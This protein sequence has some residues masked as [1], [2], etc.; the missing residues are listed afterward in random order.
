VTRSIL[1]L[2]PAH[3]EADQV[4]AVLRGIHV[5]QPDA[6]ILVV[7]DGSSDHTANVA[8]SCGARVIRHAFNLGYGAALQTGYL[9]A[10]RHGYSRVVQM[11]ADG[12]H[13]PSSIA[14]LLA[15]LDDGADVVVG[16]RYRV[17]DLSPHTSWLRRAG[18]VLL[19]W[20]V[21]KW[22][23]TKITDPTSGFQAMSDR[24]L[25][26]LVHDSFPE[27]YPDADVLIELSRAGLSLREIP[28]TMHQR[29]GGISMHRGT[30]AAYYGY[31]MMLSLSLL[32]IRRRST[33]RRGRAA[34][35]AR[36]G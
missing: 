30:R 1:F 26:A 25:E 18:S 2:I 3:D 14:G 7:D 35:A 29:A 4:G 10:R 33:V 27:D 15:G 19:S 12:Q 11:D 8:K 5:H 22:T 20:L 21:T 34:V 13:D 31:K 6:D 36:S 9:Y 32:P 28:V 16:S 17:P 24:A 23:G